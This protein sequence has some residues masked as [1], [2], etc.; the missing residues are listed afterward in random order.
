MRL[1]DQL[2]TLEWTGLSEIFR[3]DRFLHN[4]NQAGLGN[5]MLV[6][7]WWLTKY[8]PIIRATARTIMPQ[9]VFWN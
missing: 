5:E 8:L 4:M 6:V 2:L 1:L 7:D 9:A 3:M